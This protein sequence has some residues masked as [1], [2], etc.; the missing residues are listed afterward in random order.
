MKLAKCEMEADMGG[1]G[2]VIKRQE[3]GWRS[4]GERKKRTQKNGERFLCLHVRLSNTNP[5]ALS[6]N[7]KYPLY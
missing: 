5:H 4:E 1:G 2:G 7:I 6:C 3:D